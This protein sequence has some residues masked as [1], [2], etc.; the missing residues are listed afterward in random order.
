[1]AKAAPIVPPHREIR[2]VE[3]SRGDVSTDAIVVARDF[4]DSAQAADND[5]CVFFSENGRLSYDEF[6]SAH[7]RSNFFLV[8]V[9]ANGHVV[10][11]S[12]GKDPELFWRS[13][14]EQMADA[15]S[16]LSDYTIA[17]AGA[18]YRQIDAVSEERH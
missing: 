8:I 9:A 15:A 12:R 10:A 2:A 1:M 4:G 17:F 6:V 5:P 3:A 18:G 14:S 13:F 11:A 7:N 16:S